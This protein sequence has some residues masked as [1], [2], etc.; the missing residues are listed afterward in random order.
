MSTKGNTAEKKVKPEPRRCFEPDGLVERRRLPT[1]RN[2]SVPIQRM[3]GSTSGYPLFCRIP[4]SAR[5]QMMYGS[6][7]QR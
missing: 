7:F 1:V 5:L 4:T 6:R 2:Q 3:T